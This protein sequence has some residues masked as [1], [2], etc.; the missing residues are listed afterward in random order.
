MKGKTGIN[1]RLTSLLSYFSTGSAK[2][3]TDPNII[4]IR[5]AESEFNLA[6]RNKAQQMGMS[7]LDWFEWEKN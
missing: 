3:K 5:H 2:L 6:C 1:L 7:H 4:M